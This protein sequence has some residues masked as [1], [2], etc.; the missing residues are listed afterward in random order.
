MDDQNVVEANVRDLQLNIGLTPSSPFASS[1]RRNGN[2]RRE[3]ATLPNCF[4]TMSLRQVN[5]DRK[6]TNPAEMC[7]NISA[8]SG[9]S[10]SLSGKHP[11]HRSTCLASH[12]V[13][14]Y[15]DYADI[16]EDLQELPPKIDANNN[17]VKR[18]T[19]GVSKTFPERLHELLTERNVQ[20][21]ICWMPHGRCFKVKNSK[22]FE[23]VVMPVYFT[24]TKI[25]SFQ[26]QLNLYGF[27]R[28]TKGPDRGSYYHELFLRGMPK[29]CTRMRRQKV[30]GTGIKPLPDPENEPNFYRM[31]SVPNADT[32]DGPIKRTS[33]PSIAET[34]D[35]R[36]SPALCPVL[37]D[38]SFS[39]STDHKPMR[40]PHGKDTLFNNHTESSSECAALVVRPSVA[41]QNFWFGCK[42]E[43]GALSSDCI[44]NSMKKS[45]QENHHFPNELESIEKVKR[46]QS[47]EYA[48]QLWRSTYQIFTSVAPN[49]KP[50][51]ESTG[52][53]HDDIDHAL[54]NEADES[55]KL[56]RRRFVEFA[57]VAENEKC[58]ASGNVNRGV[59]SM[60]R[61]SLIQTSHTNAESEPFHS[62]NLKIVRNPSIARGA[63]RR[64][65]N[66]RL[67]ITNLGSLPQK[68]QVFDNKYGRRASSLSWESSSLIDFDED[69]TEAFQRRMSLVSIASSFLNAKDDQ[70]DGGA[71]IRRANSESS[72]A[73]VEDEILNRRHSLLTEL[74]F[75]NLFD[76]S[77]VASV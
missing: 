47:I 70:E 61:R 3:A 77:D 49:R 45:P 8:T 46:R 7:Q 11:R 16:P 19:G 13:H 23:K 6:T 57:Q 18:N 2:I 60:R 64:L 4:T 34:E 65:S 33:G 54:P 10:G 17:V 69:L 31:R 26:R 75:D 44:Q 22:D 59:G 39:S 24:H 38:L 51:V 37:A 5:F 43:F 71:S 66:A 12:V 30:K 62:N 53:V 42:P 55:S 21:I 36:V 29:L 56:D 20:D 67:S 68:I 1:L 58:E 14:S 73:W 48:R 76:E 9:D 63:V 72:F 25:T 40:Q 32:D 15:T 74:D 52:I 41:H 50:E 35:G 27:K 28:I